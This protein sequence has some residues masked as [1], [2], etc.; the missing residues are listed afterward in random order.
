MLYGSVLAYKIMAKQGFGHIVNTSSLEGLVPFPETVSYVTSKFGV[1]G[2]SL[3]MRVEGA[4]LGVKVSV[5]CPGYIR[6][7]IF[8]TTKL[9]SLNRDKLLKF[10]GP[11]LSTFSMSAEQC[12]RVILKGVAHNKP[13]ILVTS[14]AKIMWWLAR[15]SPTFVL[16]LVRKSFSKWR[17]K[18]RIVT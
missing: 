15:V 11:P 8:E 6:T 9:I 14:I 4:D 3:G 12:A 18:V 10:A 16:I 1:V 2:L 5:V 17:D 7:P 13:I